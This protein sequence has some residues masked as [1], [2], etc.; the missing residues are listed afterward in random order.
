MLTKTKI[1]LSIAI[2]LASAPASLTTHAFAANNYDSP[3]WAPPLYTLDVQR[4]PAV[5]NSAGS[6]QAP[7]TAAREE[8]NAPRQPSVT[9]RGY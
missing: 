8:L 2:A 1:A 6:A 7:A 4:R 5:G 3:D 9:R